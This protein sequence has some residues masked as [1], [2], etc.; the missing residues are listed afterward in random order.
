MKHSFQRLLFGSIAAAAAAAAIGF[1]VLSIWAPDVINRKGKTEPGG[2]V[3]SQSKD[4]NS[5]GSVDTSHLPK[6]GV[7]DPADAYTSQ[8]PSLMGI[9]LSDTL[10]S[11]TSRFG[12]PAG[13]YVMKNGDDPLT[14][15][16][17]DGF[18]VGFNG[19]NKVLFVEVRGKEIDAGLGGVKPGNSPDQSLQALGKPD[20]NTGYVI[21]YKTKTTI[22]KLDVDPKTRTIQSIKLFSREDAEQKV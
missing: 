10:S 12:D 4:K 3:V 18:S 21:S 9:K 22:L 20:S 19:K 8:R 17:Y 6:T 7:I 13:S 5:Q 11:V 14:V 15:Y 1:I 16:E 2:T